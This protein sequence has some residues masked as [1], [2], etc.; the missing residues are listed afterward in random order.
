M[1]RSVTETRWWWI[2]HAPVK[3]GGVI[4][5]SSDPSADCSDET[6]FREQASRLP[7]NAVWITSHLTRTKQTAAGLLAHMPEEGPVAHEIE[8]LGEQCF[9]DWQG[10]THEEVRLADREEWHRF[11]LTP[12][13][14][15][16]PG[17]ESF[18]DLLKRVSESIKQTTSAHAGRDIVCIAHGGTIRAALALALD[19][20]PERAL[21]FVVEN[22]SLTRMEHFNGAL[23]HGHESDAGSWRVSLVNSLPHSIA[24]VATDA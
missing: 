3:S 21:G 15:R 12:A 13:H 7:A 9:G 22:V 10:L 17:G 23:T 19:L 4:Y 24:K 11:W 2:R 20:D 1:N 6:V 8:A 16:P 18:A 5:G 14:N